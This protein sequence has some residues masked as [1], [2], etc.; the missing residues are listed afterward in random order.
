[1]VDWIIPAYRLGVEKMTPIALADKLATVAGGVL[2]TDP[3][4]SLH[5]RPIYPNTTEFRYFDLGSVDGNFTELEHIFSVSEEYVSGK[6]ENRIRIID[7]EPAYQDTLDWEEDDNNRLKGYIRA[8]PSPYRSVSEAPVETTSS[9]AVVTMGGGSAVTETLVDENEG[10]LV[11]ITE[12]QGSTSHPINSILSTTWESYPLSGLTFEPG[13]SEITT[14]DP[15]RKY[16][17]VRLVYNTKYHKYRVTGTDKR[18][19]QFLMH[20]YEEEVT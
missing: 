17:L 19:A 9:S 15:N 11:E 20:R 1:M 14:S 18:A 5:A 10:E 12:G 7:V 2:E 4:G 13:T 3:D 6:I 16:G 8:F